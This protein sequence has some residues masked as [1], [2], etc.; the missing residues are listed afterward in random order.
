[1]DQLLNA[2]LTLTSYKWGSGG[3]KSGNTSG[4][5]VVAENV[6]GGGVS[7]GRQSDRR[8][9]AVGAGHQSSARSRGI[10]RDDSTHQDRSW[11]RSG[12]HPG[13][14][15]AGRVQPRGRLRGHRIQ[16]LLP[17]RPGPRRGLPG[18]LNHSRGRRRSDDHHQPGRVSGR[19]RHPGRPTDPGLEQCRR[20][21]RECR[22]HPELPG[23]AQRASVSRRLHLRQHGASLGVD[24][25]PAGTPIHRHRRRHRRADPG[26]RSGQDG[27]HHG[28]RDHDRQIRRR[29]PRGETTARSARRR[30]HLLPAGHQQRS[31]ADHRKHGGRLRSRQPRVP[32]LRHRGQHRAGVD[33][34]VL[35][36]GPPGPGS[37][38]HRQLSDAGHRHHGHRPVPAVRG[39]HPGELDDPRPGRRRHLYGPLCGRGPAAGQHHVI[40]RYDPGVHR[41]PGIESEQQHRSHHTAVRPRAGRGQHRVGVRCLH[42]PHPIRS[43]GRHGNPGLQFAPPSP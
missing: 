28:R 13:R 7:A 19:Q 5:P 25:P 29:Q 38:P 2:V 4:F 31:P 14:V 26:R 40:R 24:Q 43:D 42:R 33:G 18:R 20:P 35:R 27:D 36:R 16:R 15:P 1:M 9:G 3:R 22:P 41:S 21:G 32:R 23:R 37:F 39:L 30:L 11:I 34:R 12:R 6:A 10:G 8:G 17:G